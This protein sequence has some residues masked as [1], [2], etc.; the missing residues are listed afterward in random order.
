MS[1]YDLTKRTGYLAKAVDIGSYRA[2]Q[3]PIGE[4]ESPI[5]E[6][7]SQPMETCGGLDEK[8]WILGESG[9]LTQANTYGDSQDTQVCADRD[10]VITPTKFST[11][12][13]IGQRPYQE[14]TYF[15]DGALWDNGS[16]S[17]VVGVCDGHGGSDVSNIV[18]DHFPKFLMANLRAK[19]LPLDAIHNAC[20]CVDKRIRTTDID[21]RQGSTMVA[22]LYH[23]GVV[24]FIN[25]GDS[26]AILCQRDGTVVMATEKHTP[27]SERTHIEAMG[28]YVSETIPRRV[29]GLLAVGRS[30]GDQIYNMSPCDDGYESLISCRPDIQ[31]YRVT[32]PV[33]VYL[34][35]DGVWDTIAKDAVAKVVSSNWGGDTTALVHDSLPVKN[36]NCCS[37]SFVIGE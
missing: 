24:Y 16:K 36:D 33:T 29:N 18:S 8:G 23:R 27:L 25:V 31:M 10:T 35:S 1:S 2:W 19:E 34:A 6:D 12:I 13:E 9:I 26:E 32:G 21:D 5:G 30:F 11:S 3:S 22:C 17:Y 28:G 15:V 4:D 14:D 7:E 20:R 37:V